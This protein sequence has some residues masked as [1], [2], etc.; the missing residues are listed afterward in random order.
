[1]AVRIR[2]KPMGRKHR[3]YYRIVAIDGRQPN[4]GRV[5]E[6]LGTYDPH[7]A[8]NDKTVTLRPDRVKY[9]QSVGARS[10]EKVTVLLNKFMA[11]FEA[12]AATPAEGEK[13]G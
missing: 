6:E 4:D 2:M 1:V 10:S 13:K 3:H 9:W 11:R 8:D 5:I 7:V 12:Q